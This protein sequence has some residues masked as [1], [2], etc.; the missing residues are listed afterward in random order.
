MTRSR[1]PFPRRSRL[2]GAVVGATLLGITATALVSPRAP[3]VPTPAPAA[4]RPDLAVVTV[5]F[6]VSDMDRSVAFLT[7]VLDFVKTSDVEVD[8]AAYEHLQGVF[9]LRLRVCTMRLGDEQIELTQYLAP[10]GR[11]IPIDSRSQDRWFQHVA[12]ITSDLD[13]AYARLRRHH[14][15]HA[16][17]GPQ[18]LP[19]WNAAAGGIKAFYFKDPDGHVLELL[20]FP[21]GK[22]RAK[23]HESRPSAL[24]LG[25]DHT[26]IV[27]RDT[28]ASRRWYHDVLGLDVVGE[29]E[30]HG[31]E[32]EHLNNV[33]G[34]RLRITTMRS[35]APDSTGPAIELLE[36]LAPSD[37]RPYP[38]D[39]RANDLWHWQTTLRARASDA[40]P[41][42]TAA[43]AEW[44]STGIV[45]LPDATL[46]F[47]SGLL[48]RDPDGHAIRIVTGG[49]D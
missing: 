26:A 29:S 16:S 41:D 18:R 42:P 13:A 39:S 17:S 10:E 1:I 47:R 43:G 5:G 35:P 22:G 8:G 36:Y 9:G 25:I 33:F 48:V 44:V 28:D 2:L 12:I 38:A 14:V 34:A 45:D 30:N 21:P 19:D 31:T 46:G 37:G 7:D 49:P 32:Q 27:V 23:W 11:P 6:T 4:A 24:F 20:E 40:L 3:S 15:R